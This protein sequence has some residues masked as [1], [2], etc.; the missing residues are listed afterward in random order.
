MIYSVPCYF[1]HCCYSDSFT[2]LFCITTGAEQSPIRLVKSRVDKKDSCST[3]GIG[4][5][6]WHHLILH[7][8]VHANEIGLKISCYWGLSSGSLQALS[9]ACPS[10][11]FIPYS[12]KLL[13]S[14]TFDV[15]T[16]F[17]DFVKINPQNCK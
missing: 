13:R 16:I 12:Q 17:S 15:F 6:F 4:L 7:I 3:Q 10:V 9:T 11:L 14:I 5:W 2:L 8:T 1:F